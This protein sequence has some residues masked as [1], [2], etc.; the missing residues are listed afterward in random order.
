MKPS[1]SNVVSLF[2]I[3]FTSLRGKFKIFTETIQDVRTSQDE[4]MVIP[5]QTVEFAHGIFRNR[6]TNKT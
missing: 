4:Y 5:S 3:E 2:E 1:I 6:L